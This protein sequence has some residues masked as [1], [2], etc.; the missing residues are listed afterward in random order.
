MPIEQ[1]QIEADRKAERYPKQ[2]GDKSYSKPNK[3][4]PDMPYQPYQQQNPA[5]G[6]KPIVDLQVYN[7]YRPPQ[8]P[9]QEFD[10]ALFVPQVIPNPYNYPPQWYNQYSG[11]GA[12][13]AFGSSPFAMP[14]IKNYSI[15]VTGP[16]D[17]HMKLNTIIED[18]LPSKQF[19]NS[20]NTVG[21]RKNIHSF[22]RSTF[23]KQGD[24]EDIKIHGGGSS[25]SLM[26]YLKFLELNPYN[27]DHFTTNP[28]KSLPDGILIYRSCYPIRYERYGST[29]QCAPNSIGMNLRIYKMLYEEYD[30]TKLDQASKINFDL[31]REVFYYEYVREQIIKRKE[32]PNFA[33]LYGYFI[34]EN[35]N[36]DF[37]KLSFI[38]KGKTPP[39]QATYNYLVPPPLDQNY[40]GVQP[41]AKPQYLEKNPKAYS[42]R[43]LIAL[44]EAPTNNLISWASKTYNVEGVVRRTVNTGFHSAEIWFSV[45]FQMMAALYTMQLHNIVLSS[46]TIEDNVYIKDIALHNNITNY[47]KYVIDGIEYY[48][49][50][51]GYLVMI[52]SNFKDV[53]EKQG[54]ECADDKRY[55][56]YSRFIKAYKE[57]D[58]KSM[59]YSAFK[60]AVDPDNFSNSATNYG[61]V[62]PDEEVLKVLGNMKNDNNIDKNIG[63]YFSRYMTM[64]MNNRVGT[65]LKETEAKNVRR[66]DAKPF[67]KGQIVINEYQH[68]TYKFVIF[69]SNQNGTAKILTKEDGTDDII[70]KNVA[71][72]TLFNYAIN[73]T[74]VQ[75]YKADE[76]NLSEDNLLETYVIN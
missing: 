18:V 69:L 13:A 58:L 34:C 8:K 75:N 60:R 15:N 61:L 20:Y 11:Y 48:I 29:T 65:I 46:F 7:T 36:I 35:C 42:G 2:S 71:I 22:V 62:K 33:M 19:S 1:Q 26:S 70:E 32:C 59:S 24:G 16:L 56:I 52:D 10:P 21:E 38:K 27:T 44:T 63:Y 66:D 53:Q 76:A 68:D 45:I 12:P 28:Y 49:P 67:K 64:F 25:D 47:W 9:K 43:C 23:I 31:W 57:C 41:N 37:N 72:G 6:Q 17:D 73:E 14:V 39:A 55:K 54:V 4:D 5:P 74:I 50:N 51:Y 30:A 40:F 3:Y